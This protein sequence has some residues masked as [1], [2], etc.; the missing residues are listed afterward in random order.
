MDAGAEARDSPVAAFFRQYER[1]DDDEKDRLF[2]DWKRRFLRRTKVQNPTQA[3]IER[4]FG[5]YL[6][7]G[8]RAV[9]KGLRRGGREGFAA[10]PGNADQKI[11]T[12]LGKAADTRMPEFL[13]VTVYVKKIKLVSNRAKANVR[14]TGDEDLDNLIKMVYVGHR[15]DSKVIRDRVVVADAGRRAGSTNGLNMTLRKLLNLGL[16]YRDDFDF[17][18]IFTKEVLG[19]VD[20]GHGMEASNALDASVLEDLKRMEYVLRFLNGTGPRVFNSKIDNSLLGVT[21]ISGLLKDHD[22]P[23]ED[24]NV[25][26]LKRKL[27]RA[28]RKLKLK[29]KAYQK[30]FIRDR[31]R[32][33]PVLPRVGTT[34]DGI[35]Q[36]RTAQ[37]SQNQRKRLRPN[38]LKNPF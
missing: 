32:K 33:V 3:F 35:G 11:Q 23:A 20:H 26:A 9:A 36:V 13:W 27:G 37:V 15:R 29:W 31:V 16:K 24:L 10:E 17:D 8:R 6:S 1:G 5:Q 18:E 25:P 28:Q 14:D 30:L 21:N 34:K 12:L 22:I 19:R 4:R 38:Q 7:L 2:E